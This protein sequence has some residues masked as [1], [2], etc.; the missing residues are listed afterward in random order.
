[1]SKIPL[2]APTGLR[3][4]V[5]AYRAKP[6]VGARDASTSAPTLLFQGNFLYPP[7]CDAAHYLV[8]EILPA[9]REVFPGG[10]EL[11]LV[12]KGDRLIRELGNAEEV[13]VVG[14]VDRIEDELG[15]ADVCVVPL[16]YGTGTRIKILEAWSHQIPAVSTTTGADGLGAVNGTHLLIAD[17]PAEFANACRQAIDDA[18]LRRHLAANGHQLLVRRFDVDTVEGQVR[19]IVASI[20]G[21]KGQ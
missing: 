13:T 3:I 5:N 8:E 9:L 4:V 2:G 21:G 20:P 16:R 14:Y 15:R 19:A 12:G 18:A 17:S 11:R 7:N 1:V 6:F 10:F